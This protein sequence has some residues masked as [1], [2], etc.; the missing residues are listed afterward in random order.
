MFEPLQNNVST[1]QIAG[2]VLILFIAYRIT[3]KLYVDARLRKLG[4]RA[5]IRRSYWPYSIDIAYEL[6]TH[7]LADRNYDFWIKMF[8]KWAPKQ[9]TLE[10]GIAERVILTAEPENVK[11]ILATQFKEFGKGEAFH[12]DFYDFLGNG[13]YNFHD[14]SL[15]ALS[16]ANWVADFPPIG[17][18][19]VDGQLWH[20][21]RQLI[22]PQFVK[23][24][25]SDLNIFEEHVQILLQRM[26]A[27]PEV[28]MMDL[29]FR[30]SL[31]AAT[32]FLL[33]KSVDSLRQTRA[34]FADAFS[35][36]QHVQGLIARMG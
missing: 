22:R 15:M 30:Y 36:A 3:S 18:F 17:I 35:H 16:Q 5:P 4:A 34:V 33:G 13:R 2:A 12:K 28:D 9:W 25:V 31:D 27:S 20:N 29:F 14:P 19:A 7:S 26:S 23:D 32:H 21:S 24:R 11:A 6:I 10:A 1:T 8:G